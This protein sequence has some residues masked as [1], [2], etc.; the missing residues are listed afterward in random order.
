MYQTEL[1]NI[2]IGYIP[3]TNTTV[4][5]LLIGTKDILRQHST[6]CYECHPW[7]KSNLTKIF[8]TKSIPYKFIYRKS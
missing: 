4:F 6:M 3:N 2:T 5:I 8:L 7:W 1:N